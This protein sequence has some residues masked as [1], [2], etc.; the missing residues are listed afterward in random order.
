MREAQLQSVTHRFVSAVNEMVG[1][2]CG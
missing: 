2:A 1:Y